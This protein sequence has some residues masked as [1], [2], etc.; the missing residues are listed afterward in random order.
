[1][2]LI[3]E[4]PSSETYDAILVC[5]DRFTKM[6]HFIPTRSNVTAEQAASLYMKDVFR[7]HGLPK[8]IVSDRGQQ[9]TSH[10]TK[11]LL[12][13]C[14]IKSNLSTA[15]HPQSDGQTERT[16]QTLEQYLRIYGDYQ[17]DHWVELLPYV[18][19]M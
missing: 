14:D 8:D 3:T 12:E 17:R 5:V 16:N 9:F 2:D 19:F 11:R 10:F 1:M 6:A 15:Y 4:L 18:E 7:L 13:L